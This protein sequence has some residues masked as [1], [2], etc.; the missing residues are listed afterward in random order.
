MLCRKNIAVFR[1]LH[2][3]CVIDIWYIVIPKGRKGLMIEYYNVER[4]SEA[5]IY[6]LR[7]STMAS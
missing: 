6:Q 5:K 3:L 1:I 7:F 2:T 4:A